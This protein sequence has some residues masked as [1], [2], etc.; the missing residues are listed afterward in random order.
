LKYNCAVQFKEIDETTGSLMHVACDI[1]N[2]VILKSLLEK[3]KLDV[4]VEGNYKNSLTFL[5]M[6]F[7]NINNNR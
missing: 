1:G 5:T 4:D 2:L 3:G 6:K 7:N